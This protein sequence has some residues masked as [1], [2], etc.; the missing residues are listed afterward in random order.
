MVR[1]VV[2]VLGAVVLAACGQTGAVPEVGADWTPPAQSAAPSASAAE[3][4]AQR[5]EDSIGSKARK[6]KLATGQP[7]TVVVP[8][9]VGLGLQEARSLWRGQGLALLRA[10]DASGRN[11]S[12]MLESDWYVVD[13]NPPAGALVEYGSGVQAMVLRHGE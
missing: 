5:P 6:R 9:A 12:V 1:V 11:R 13:Q 3:E 2:A 10:T 4:S 8:D 7:V